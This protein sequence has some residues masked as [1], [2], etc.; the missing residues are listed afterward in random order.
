MTLHYC[1]TLLDWADAL[2]RRR[3]SPEAFQQ[4]R[5]LFDT[6]ARILGPRPR[7]RTAPGAGS[8]A[9]RRLLRPASRP[10]PRLMGLYDLVADRLELIRWSL[11]A[12]AAQRPRGRDMPYFGDS[13]CRRLASAEAAPS[14][15]D[16]CHPPSPYRF[17]FLIQKAI[18]LAGQVRELGAALLAAYEKG[19]AE[20]LASMRAEQEREMLALLAIRQDQWRDAD[21][22]VQALQQTKDINQTNLLY[23][24]D[25]YQN[26][27]HQ[28]RDPEPGPDHERPADPHRRQRGRS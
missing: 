5:L 14:E 13:R 7:D 27:L 8:A 4:A 15:D 21:W 2:M 22:Q 20:Y 19:D 10:E 1:Q 6:A 11:D 24:T 3:R 12:A 17:M 23:Y 25:L 16:W 18:E 26:G 28:R 9:D